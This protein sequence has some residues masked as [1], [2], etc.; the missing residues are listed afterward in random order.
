MSARRHFVKGAPR[1]KIAVEHEG[2]A[3]RVLAI[4]HAKRRG[5][6]SIFIRQQNERQR[7][8]FRERAM[9]LGRVGAHADDDAIQRFELF[10]TVAKFLALDRAAG[11]VVLRIEI[12]DDVVAV[13]ILEPTNLAASVRQGESRAPPKDRDRRSRQP[14][15]CASASAIDRRLV[16]LIAAL[17]MLIEHSDPHIVQ[18]LEPAASLSSL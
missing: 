1:A 16:N 8:L 4:E 9:T 12:D 2:R 6:L 10:D 7:M 5:E 18:T 13:K 11:R 3:R 17:S 15:A 14:T